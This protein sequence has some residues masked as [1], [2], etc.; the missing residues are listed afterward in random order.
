MES[1]SPT[2]PPA[3]YPRAFER[4][5]TLADGRTVFVRPIVPDDAPELA[6]AF[7]TADP[8]T[9]RSR[10][11]GGAPSLNTRLLAHLT[12]VDYINRFALVAR[13]ATTGRGV[14]ITR[15]ESPGG[16]SAEA[17]V[18]VDPAWRRVGLATVLVEMLAEAA[19]DH[20]ITS[21]TAS[22]LAD[23]QPVAALLAGADAGRQQIRQGITES[24]VTFDRARIAARHPHD[25]DR[26][27]RTPP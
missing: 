22:Y 7:R 13:D 21:F 23:N 26:Q 3:G 27:G 20:G 17:A 2:S 6:E 25:P 10:F 18:A 11:L 14:A 1:F 4:T 9:L 16:K 24:S 12:Q 15:Y 5:A 19:L 8:D